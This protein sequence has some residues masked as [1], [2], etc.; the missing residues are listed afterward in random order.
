MLL[1]FASKNRFAWMSNGSFITKNFH[2]L[3]SVAWSHACIRMYLR[4]CC[5]LGMVVLSFRAGMLSSIE[6]GCYH[7]EQGCYH[8]EQGCYH[9]EQGGYHQRAMVLSSGAGY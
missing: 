7:L 9:L 6:Q 3:L 8:L 5:H 4:R 1:K 2:V